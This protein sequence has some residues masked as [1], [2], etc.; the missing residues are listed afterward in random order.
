MTAS[1]SRG[2][3]IATAAGVIAISLMLAFPAA[4]ALDPAPDVVASRLL[5]PRGIFLGDDGAILVAEAGK[6]GTARVSPVPK[7]DRSALG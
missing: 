3:S 1:R 7:A 6:G 2:S 5:N 4:A